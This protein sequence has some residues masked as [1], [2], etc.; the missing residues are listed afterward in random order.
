MEK[1]ATELNLEAPLH[2][3]S[4]S[5]KVTYKHFFDLADYHFELPIDF[6][7]KLSHHIVFGKARDI[8]KSRTHKLNWSLAHNL[9]LTLMFGINLSFFLKK[10]A[11]RIT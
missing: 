2:S 4:K 10:N 7:Q 5:Y 11:Q 1:R 3:V 8:I 9:A 6:G